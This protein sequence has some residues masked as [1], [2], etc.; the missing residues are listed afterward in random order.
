MLDHDST[1]IVPARSTARL[2]SDDGATPTTRTRR[3]HAA[4]ITADIS[5]VASVRNYPVVQTRNRIR[6][7]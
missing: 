4:R 6:L 2:A 5:V 3:R 7:D 1:S